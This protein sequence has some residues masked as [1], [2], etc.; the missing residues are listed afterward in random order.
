MS[1]GYLI[2]LILMVTIKFYN[3]FLLLKERNSVTIIF[4]NSAQ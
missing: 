4:L 3:Y 1:K 2:H